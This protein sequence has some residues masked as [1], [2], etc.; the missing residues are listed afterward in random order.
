MQLAQLVPGA[1]RRLGQRQRD[2]CLVATRTG[3]EIGA[4]GSRLNHR[5]RGEL[6]QL[7]GRLL[8]DRERSKMRPS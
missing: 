6:T 1:A 7:R 4:A 8:A 2:V 3:S 5:S